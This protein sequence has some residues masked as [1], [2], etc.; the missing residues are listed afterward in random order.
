MERSLMPPEPPLSDG[1]VVLRPWRREDA[2]ALAS[3]WD[4]GDSELA[5]WMDEVPQPY[6]V[7]DAVAYV[8]RSE[9]GWRGEGPA[10]PFAVCAGASAELLGWL[11]LMWDEAR[12]GTVEAAYWTRRETR[13][14]G[15]ATQALRLAASWVLG[16]L[17]FERMELRIDSRNEPSRRV[18]AKAGFSLD[19]IRRSACVNARD[20]RRFDEAIYSLLRSEL[21]KARLSVR[22]AGGW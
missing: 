13:G 19:G 5:Y 7:T 15:V 8:D 10:T 2:P 12:E 4:S 21:P 3:V 14:R 16:D 6:T 20:G 1:E 18:A 17:G 11:G 22:D 9:A